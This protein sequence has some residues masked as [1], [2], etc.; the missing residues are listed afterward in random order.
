MLAKKCNPTIFWYITERVKKKKKWTAKITV[1]S[2]Y[3]PEN[4]W[5][6]VVNVFLTLTACVVKQLSHKDT[7]IY[8][9]TNHVISLWPKHIRSNQ[10]AS[11]GTFDSTGLRLLLIN[12][13]FIQSVFLDPLHS[14]Q[15]FIWRT[16]HVVLKYKPCQATVCCSG[17]FSTSVCP[18]KTTTWAHSTVPLWV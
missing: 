17:P 15:W 5:S 4:I 13:Y 14:P 16:L 9:G 7:R 12:R 11:F 6:R 1:A 2:L 10:S 18:L 8:L 3:R